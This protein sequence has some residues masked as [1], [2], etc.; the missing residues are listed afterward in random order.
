MIYKKTF[1]SAMFLLIWG[2]GSMYAQQTIATAGGEA[3]GDGGTVSYTV[4]QMV[5]SSATG[6]TGTVSQGIQQPYEIFVLTG[7]EQKGINL[8][9]SAYPNP[10]TESL[11]LK[12]EKSTIQNMSY[13]LYDIQGRLIKSS[14][15]LGNNTQIDMTDLEPASY[16]LKVLNDDQSLKNFKIIKN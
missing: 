13:Q 14:M 8:N 12:V 9:I 7:V 15:L 11:N 16:I 10:T 5:Y 4:G 3:E 2:L 1:L 6:S